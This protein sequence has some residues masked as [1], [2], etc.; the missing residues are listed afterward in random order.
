MEMGN[1]WF[2]IF[3][4]SFRFSKC[5]VGLLWASLF[6]LAHSLF[7]HAFLL[8]LPGRRCHNIVSCTVAQLLSS[9]TKIIHLSCQCSDS[10]YWKRD[11]FCFEF[12]YLGTVWLQI[13][14][15]ESDTILLLILTSDTLACIG[16]ILM[17]V[18]CF[19]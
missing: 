17:P 16:L 15:T 11:C 13:C 7:C 4:S 1:P 3:H 18:L 2:Q 19:W 10:F 8:F 5:S 14:N 6:E 9:N 12:F